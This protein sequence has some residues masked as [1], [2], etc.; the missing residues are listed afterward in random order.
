MSKNNLN[1]IDIFKFIDIVVCVSFACGK[2][3]KKEKRKM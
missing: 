2:N 1:K 3:I